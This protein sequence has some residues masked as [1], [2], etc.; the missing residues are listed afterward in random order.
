M[1]R[2][3]HQPIPSHLTATAAGLT[4]RLQVLGT[5]PE[6][7]TAAWIRIDPDNEEKRV[8]MTPLPVQAGQ[9]GAVWQGDIPLDAIRPHT[10]YV[11]KVAVDEGRRWL[12]A[13]GEHGRQPPREVAFK[14]AHQP[15]PD[16]V[17]EQ[18]FYQIFPDRFRNGDP[19]LNEP[20]GAYRYL[21]QRAMRSR[22]WHEAPRQEDGPNEF[23]HGDLPGVT[24]GLDYLQNT[25]GI[26]AIYLNPVF[27]SDSSHKYDTLDYYQVDPRLGGN[28]ALVSLR[29]ETRERGMRLL[30]DGVLN[31]TSVEHDWFQRA[32]AGERPY[33]DYY[34][35][36]DG[37]YASWK[38]H[39]SLP[40]LDFSN[41]DVVDHCYAGDHSVLRHWLRPPY[42]ADGW[43]LDVI[44]ML[45]EGPGARNNARHVQA[46]RRVIKQEDP[47]AYLLGE[48]FFEATAWLQGDQE[49]AAMNYYGFMHPLWMFLAG[50]DLN[51]DP[52]RLSGHELASWMREARAKLPFQIA[53]CQFNLLDSHDT[54]RL[55]T[56]LEGNW[57][58]LVMAVRLQMAYLGVPCLYY[59][60]EIGLQGGEDPDCRRPF[61]W[62]ESHWHHDLL[63]ASQQ[64]IAWRKAL[65]ALREG[66]VLDLD[67]GEDHWVFARF[68]GEQ[69]VLVAVNRSNE[70]LT[71]PLSSAQLPLAGRTWRGLETGQCLETDSDGAM[72]LSVAPETTRLWRTD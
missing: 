68:T 5:H 6:A 32:R 72:V 54:P 19:S 44:H 58:R 43:R 2:L 21:G 55:L 23:F 42:S 31:H 13:D 20:D 1:I 10:P 60:D 9:T 16:W 41:P 29:H 39:K 48:H 56:L 47:E 25:L 57:R 18:I 52:A 69:G 26:T 71:I 65:P 12:A 64:A 28:E 50:R 59:G 37:D 22:Q 34:L 63:E 8:P 14:W 3:Y 70:P 30:L 24:E 46:M 49:D 53:R 66:G 11:F 36:A 40:V 35:D 67:T 61:P 15:P 45:G 7:V 38:G 62:H 4:L 51:R 17:A 27:H 33:C